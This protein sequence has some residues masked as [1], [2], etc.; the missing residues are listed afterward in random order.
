V[1]LNVVPTSLLANVRIMLFPAL[2]P[3]AGT[4]TE[5]VVPVVVLVWVP[6][7]LT[8]WILAKTVRAG[9]KTARLSRRAAPLSEEAQA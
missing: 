9:T 6:T 1:A 5:R 2:T 8:N 3:P 7:F 4:V